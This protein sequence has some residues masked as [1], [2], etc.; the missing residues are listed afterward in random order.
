MDRPHRDMSVRWA[1]PG[2]RHGAGP[3]VDT[4]LLSPFHE[5]FTDHAVAIGRRVVFQVTGWNSPAVT[6]SGRVDVVG[7]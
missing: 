6:R 1:E 4:A 5:R 3:A 7:A 2:W